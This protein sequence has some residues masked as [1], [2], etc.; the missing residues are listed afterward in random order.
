MRAFTNK[1]VKLT[2]NTALI[3]QATD[4]AIERGLE[5]V[6]MEIERRAKVICNTRYEKPPID[7]GRMWNSI[8]HATQHNRGQDEYK[9]DNEEQYSGGQAKG[10]PEEKT[11]YVGTNVEYSPY[12]ELGTVKMDPRPFLR[13]AATEDPET[14]KKIFETQL[15]KG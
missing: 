5:A 14:L 13:P 2:D 7:T 1:N 15:K 6:G 10:D 4:E 9:D 8:T 12:V 11:V 3:K